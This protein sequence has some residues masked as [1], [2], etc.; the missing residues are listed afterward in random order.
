[1]KSKKEQPCSYWEW[2]RD[3]SKRLFFEYAGER[4]YFGYQKETFKKIIE[5]RQYYDLDDVETTLEFL[6][7]EKKRPIG[8]GRNS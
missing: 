3:N 5:K 7:N 6:K 1:M 4:G 8:R 2:C